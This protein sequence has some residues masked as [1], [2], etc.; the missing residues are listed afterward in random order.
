MIASSCCQGVF[1]LTKLRILLEQTIRFFS[2]F[3]SIMHLFVWLISSH[4]HLF[5]HSYFGHLSLVVSSFSSFL[6]LS[7]F[8]KL[9]KKYWST[10]SFFLLTQIM[11]AK[12]MSSI[13]FPKAD[14]ACASLYPS[15]DIEYPWAMSE[16]RYYLVWGCTSIHIY[17]IL[18][19]FHIR[20]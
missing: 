15:F 4:F 13:V 6:Q 12:H 14:L 17:A 7:G 9:E 1:W 11:P 20:P 5:S 3:F 18:E 19:M 8:S 2:L 16:H 10:S